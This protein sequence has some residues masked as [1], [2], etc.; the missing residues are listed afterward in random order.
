VFGQAV[1]FTASVTAAAPGSGVPTGTV[2]FYDG[3]TVLGTGTLDGTGHASYSTTAFQLTIGAGQ[4]ITA[5][6]A[7]DGNYTSSTS[8][9]VNQDVAKDATTESLVSSVPS[10]VYGQAVTFTATVTARAPGSGV[11]TGTVTFYEGATALGSGSLDASG[12]ASYSTTAFQLGVG[13][14]QSITAVYIGDT[15]YAGGTSPAT[16][17]DVAKDATATSVVSSSAS[18]VYGQSLTFT[19]TVTASAPGS[20]TPTGNV[21]FYRGSTLLGTGALDATGHASYTTTAFQLGVGTG[22]SVTAVYSG[23]A[24]YL[25]SASAAISQD[26]AKDTTAVTVASSA[27]SAVYGQAVTLTASVTASAPGSGVP[28][29]SISFY[30]GTTLL[31]SGSL[32]VTGHASYTTTAF[33]LAVASRQSI[34]AVY[35]GDGNYLTS[36]SPVITQDVNK[37]AT[38]AA[39]VSSSASSVYGQAVTF[40]ATVTAV[41]PGSGTP[42]GSVTFMDGSTVLGI[43]SLDATGHAAYTTTALQLAVGNGQ[44]ITAVYAGDGNYVASTSPAISLDVA[45]DATTT[46]VAS[47]QA[48]AVYG[49]AVTFTATVTASAPGSGVPTGSVTFKDGSTVLG[50]GTLDATGH[51]SY[52]TTAFQLAVGNGQSITTV[53]AGDS[54]YTT[55]TSAAISQ[56]V[57]KDATSATV[58]SS[59]NPSVYGQAVTFT[60]TVTAAALGSGVPTGGVSFYDGGTLLGTGTLDATGHATYTTTAFQLAV[61]SGQSITGVYAGDGNYATSTSPAVGQT[62]N[63]DAT[64]V[65]LASSAT[66]TSFG[67]AVTFTATVTASAPGLGTP[68]GTV[69]FYDGTAALAIFTV[70]ASAKAV[71]TTATLATGSHPIKAVY[72]ADAQYATSTSAT[73]TQTIN[74]VATSTTVASSQNPSAVGESVTFTVTVTAPAGAPTGTITFKDGSTVLGTGTLQV[75]MG[76]ADQATFTTSALGAGDHAITAVYGG[77]ANN[78]GGTSNS[79]TQT[80]NGTTGSVPTTTVASVIGT[81]VFGQALTFTAVVSAASGTPAGSVDFFDTTTETD[82]GTAAL[83]GGTASLTVTSLPTGQQTIQ[84]TYLGDGNDL[85]SSDSL[86]VTP[87]TSIYVMSGIGS[88]ALNL[89][90]N[91]SV[92]IPGWLVVDSNSTAAAQ[93][94]GN[95]SVT[96][97]AVRI[98]GGDQVSGNAGFSVTPVTGVATQSDPLAA[99][100]APSVT[101]NIGSV[102]LGG[103]DSLTICPGVYSQINVSGHA[104]LTLNPGVY[105]I[106][107]GGFTASGSAVVLGNGVFIYNAGAN[108]PA[109]GGNTGGVSFS[110]NAVINLQ[111]PA[112]GVY[113]GIVLAQ[114][115]Y[116]TRAIS[117]SGNQQLGLN[118]G[119]VYAPSA[120]LTVGGNA[121]VM[122]SPLVV[123][124]LQLSGNGSSTLSA[125]G[126]DSESATAGQLLATN[127]VVYVDNSAGYFTT[128][129]LAEIGDAI[130]RTNAFLAPYHVT[131]VEGGAADANVVVSMTNSTDAGGASQGVLGAESPGAIDIVHGWNWYTGSGTSDIAAGQ[132]DFETV[133]THEL[134]HALGLGHNPDATSV[135]HATLSAGTVERN[136]VVADLGI[137]DGD[138]GGALHAAPATVGVIPPFVNTDVVAPFASAA[139][140]VIPLTPAFVPVVTPVLAY[141]PSSAGSSRV[142]GDLPSVGVAPPEWVAAGDVALPDDFVISRYDPAP[143]VES[144]PA[145]VGQETT[146]P[147]VLPLTATTATES[148]GQQSQKA[149][150]TRSGWGWWLLAMPAM[151]QTA[152]LR[153]RDGRGRDESRRK[154]D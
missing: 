84:L 72:N 133:F 41:A 44:A 51:A 79:L 95:A 103:S 46:S 57:T 94:S 100:P 75:G 30:D 61:A 86:T 68:T 104:R 78:L 153:L 22:Q 114:P 76:G 127:L 136:F 53:Y 149:S 24:G 128:A 8:P 71:F 47:S 31:G 64:S 139:A 151:F 141:L 20:G 126:S 131:V 17:Q 143:T 118:G 144:A 5:V 38:S 77:D 69:T 89:S 66:T 56:N 33:Q 91:S 1:T 142:I 34:T 88:S 35:A 119:A 137:P 121:Q 70:D 112:T 28:T 96:A 10:A 110:G 97:S 36:T 6:Y 42:S 115:A 109:A 90:G 92:N 45:K 105:V 147:I 140:T 48:S 11:P 65:A 85:A 18:S 60:A 13:T 130:T 134:G 19:A 7:G 67:Q 4:S 32:D 63:P 9:A 123:A 98:V 146:A 23:D 16:S 49:Q 25:T 113:A 52:T 150:G 62:V 27:P 125:D 101:N 2:T 54:N 12:H 43:V 120:L 15:N 124:R 82:L 73:V 50:T 55:S 40:T 26:V 132:Y 99:L 148:D 145:P 138:G 106:A 107:G 117:L 83:S 111:A 58:A 102:N 87:T 93:L 59:A 81:Q 129:E 21:S 122:H 74:A 135:M 108:Y 80:V 37:A 29:G 154:R 152:V 14:G 116:N 39:V 3:A